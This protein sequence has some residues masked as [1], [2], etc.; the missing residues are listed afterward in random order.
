MGDS[1]NMNSNMK[2]RA[3][4]VGL[5]D[6]V[7]PFKH[8]I[9]DFIPDT[10]YTCLKLSKGSHEEYLIYGELFYKDTFNTKFKILRKSFGRNK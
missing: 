1:S 7:K 5:N 6:N 8:G 4:T 9:T 10:E 2:M 3:F